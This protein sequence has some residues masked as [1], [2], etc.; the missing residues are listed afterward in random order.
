MFSVLLRYLVD[1]KMHKVMPDRNMY[2]KEDGDIIEF[3]LGAHVFDPKTKGLFLKLLLC[4]DYNSLYPSLMLARNL[5][6]DVG[7]VAARM[8][9]YGVKLEDCHRTSRKFINPKTRL[10]EYY[11]FQQP[12][13]RTRAQAEAEGLKPEDCNIIP[14]KRNVHF[15]KKRDDEH[16]REVRRLLDL[17]LENLNVEEQPE[18]EQKSERI[19]PPPGKIEAYVFEDNGRF[20]LPPDKLTEQY[21]LQNAIGCIVQVS[22]FWSPKNEDAALRER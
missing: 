19:E 15:Y 6:H 5:G 12:K 14:S 21:N 9:K 4:M 20:S 8:L 13:K 1:E 11:Y 18:V 10:P 22:E 16:T 2:S 7:G 3:F 17:Q